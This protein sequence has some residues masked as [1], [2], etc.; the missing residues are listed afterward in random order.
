MII[1]SGT[2]NKL[3]KIRMREFYGIKYHD[4]KYINNL[5]VQSTKK[6]GLIIKVQKS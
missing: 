2:I 3:T 5:L 4:S 1:W 6:K